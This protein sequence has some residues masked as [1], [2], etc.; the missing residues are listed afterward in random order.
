LRWGF[1]MANFDNN[2]RVNNAGV[3]EIIGNDLEDDLIDISSTFLLP[4]TTSGVIDGQGGS[5]SLRIDGSNLF[6]VDISNI[7]ATEIVDNMRLNFANTASPS[8]LALAAGSELLAD[9]VFNITIQGQ[10]AGDQFALDF[11]NLAM[12]SDSRLR[13]PARQWRERF[14]HRRDGRRHTQRHQRRLCDFAWRRWR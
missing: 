6:D 13:Q 1:P 12:A 3:T 10:I 14:N 2:S 5:D 9:Q 8:I 7:E 4:G 11:S